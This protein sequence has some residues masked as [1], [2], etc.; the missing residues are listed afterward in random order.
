[1]TI[2]TYLPKNIQLGILKHCDQLGEVSSTSLDIIAAI[3]LLAT[4]EMFHVNNY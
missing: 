4:G 1:M 3:R 2:F